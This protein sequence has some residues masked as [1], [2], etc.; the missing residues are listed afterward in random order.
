MSSKNADKIKRVNT[1]L[2]S[3]GTFIRGYVLL[4]IFNIIL[5]LLILSVFFELI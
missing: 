1:F 4:S 5:A 3:S 2:L